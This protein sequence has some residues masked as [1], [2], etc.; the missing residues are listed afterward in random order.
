MAQ[1]IKKI[2][3]QHAI[4]TKTTTA[5]NGPQFFDFPLANDIMCIDNISPSSK[6][7]DSV[8][9]SNKYIWR[10]HIDILGLPGRD[11][12]IHGPPW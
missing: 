8:G 1:K 9:E 10:I 3:R 7:I 4:R 6:A 12:Y 2:I 5:K 11:I